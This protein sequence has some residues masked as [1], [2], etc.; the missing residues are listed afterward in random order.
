MG[1]SHPTSGL[2]TTGHKQSAKQPEVV[3]EPLDLWFWCK[4]CP[5]RGMYNVYAGVPRCPF[6]TGAPILEAYALANPP[7]PDPLNH[8]MKD[9]DAWKDEVRRR[10]D[11][12]S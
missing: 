1:S 7:K 6:C 4:S 5:H 10:Q 8:W 12:G 3:V 11:T 2:H 9:N